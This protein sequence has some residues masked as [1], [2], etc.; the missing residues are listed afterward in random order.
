MPSDFDI[1]AVRMPFRKMM[2]ENIGVG[3][4]IV[5][6]IANYFCIVDEAANAISVSNA[7][8]ISPGRASPK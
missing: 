4:A 2:S 5:W 6:G 1:S 3:F 8:R 7:P